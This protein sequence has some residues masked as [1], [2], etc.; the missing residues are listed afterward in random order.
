M[1]E[2]DVGDQLSH[3]IALYPISKLRSEIRGV[4]AGSELLI[5]HRFDSWS[6]AD[7]LGSGCQGIYHAILY[8]S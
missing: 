3:L 7:D 5:T 6:L 4:Y 2:L 8:N 1:F